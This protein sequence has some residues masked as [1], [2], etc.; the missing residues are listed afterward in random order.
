MDAAH[1]F[2]SSVDAARRSYSV[3]S[4][5]SSSYASSS[6]A[7][8][9]PSQQRRSASSSS[10][11]SALAFSAHA[12]AGRGPESP[13]AKFLIGGAVTITFEL[14][15]GHFV[16]MLKIVKQTSNDSYF[17]IARKLTSKGVAGTLDGFFPWGFTQAVAKGSVFSWGQAASMKA[18]HDY[19]GVSKETKTIASGG[20]G[21]FVQGVAMSPLL[22]LK[23]RVMTD[24]AFRNSGGLVATA[25]A[26]A[27]VGARVVATEGPQALFK[28]VGVFSAKRALDWTTRYLFVVMVENAL[29]EYNVSGGGA[30]KLSD[31][32]VVFSALAGGSISALSTIPMDVLVAAKQSAAGAGKAVSVMET[33][34]SH[35]GVMGGIAFATKGLVARC[36]HVGLTTLMMKTMTTVV[37]DLLYPEPAK[38][39]ASH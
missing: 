17:T 33:F 1:R 7:S 31:G 11:A 34:T 18:M 23:T 35:G 30:A 22:L 2:L 38:P 19:P 14:C 3:S 13:F 26:S 20:A 4:S 5:S 24:P 36:V 8:A 29:K 9:S 37:Y 10:S 15:G 39:A 27:R 32:Q 16:E 21:G 6:Y 25:V 28:G 12:P